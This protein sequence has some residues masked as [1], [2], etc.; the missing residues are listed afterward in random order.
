MMSV[1]SG[2][3]LLRSSEHS[4]SPASADKLSIDMVFKT[5]GTRAR[6]HVHMH[7]SVLPQARNCPWRLVLSLWWETITCGGGGGG[8]F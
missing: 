2:E 1:T 3:C 6:L 7:H 4:V 8:T 5:V